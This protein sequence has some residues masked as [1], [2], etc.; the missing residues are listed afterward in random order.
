MKYLI[1]VV[2]VMKVQNESNISCGEQKKKNLSGKY[3]GWCT[4]WEDWL[5]W[6]PFG[7]DC[8]ILFPKKLVKMSK[9]AKNMK[10]WRS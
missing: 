2:V 9:S 4:L 7:A 10:Y 3:Q 5:S 1:W 8:T 6:N